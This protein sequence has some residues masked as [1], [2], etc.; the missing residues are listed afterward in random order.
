MDNSP[1]DWALNFHAL[2]SEIYLRNF[3]TTRVENVM[4]CIYLILSFKLDLEEGYKLIH[5]SYQA[6]K[7]DNGQV[8]S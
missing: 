8:G 7:G 4:L 5:R 2:Y 3:R 1:A 6:K